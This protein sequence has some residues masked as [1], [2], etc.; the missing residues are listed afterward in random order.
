MSDQ[1]RKQGQTSKG[2]SWSSRPPSGREGAAGELNYE[3]S[4]PPF[5]ALAR[6]RAPHSPPPFLPAPP[7]IHACAFAPA[8][9]PASSTCLRCL[10]VGCRPAAP[11][12]PPW[13]PRLTSSHP[14]T[15]RSIS[16]GRALSNQVKQ[17]E[18]SY[19]CLIVRRV[20]TGR[21]NVRPGWRCRGRPSDQA[22]G[23][24]GSGGH[25]TRLRV[26]GETLGGGWGERGGRKL[27]DQ[28]LGAG[29]NAPTGCGAVRASTRTAPL[30]KGPATRAAATPP[31][32]P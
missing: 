25:P 26:R 8:K 15:T 9:R 23:E 12:P 22:G 1:K 7:P 10:Q 31:S 3:R 14:G 32:R 30:P 18:C 13:G 27:S 19:C 11:G 2:P 5:P 4:P 24:R 16:R 6:D 17:L 21:K 20:E 29:G 28:A